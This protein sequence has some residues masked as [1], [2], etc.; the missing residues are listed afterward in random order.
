MVISR[1]VFSSVLGSLS[2]YWGVKLQKIIKS[3]L[4]FK[5]FFA[6]I[7]KSRQIVAYVCR[8]VSLRATGIVFERF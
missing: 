2:L 7:A 8:I 6:F 1:F 3:Q 5:D 4:L